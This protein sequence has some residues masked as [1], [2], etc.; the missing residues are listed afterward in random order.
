VHHAELG[1]GHANVDRGLGVEEG[2][3][4]SGSVGILGLRLIGMFAGLLAGVLRASQYTLLD[5]L[6][7]GA[8]VEMV[9]NVLGSLVLLI[10]ETVVSKVC[11]LD[12]IL[13]KV[14]LDGPDSRTQTVN[15]E[16]V[17]RRDRRGG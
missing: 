4:L 13:L 11:S 12:E 17:R 10:R 7:L 16:S 15:A 1:L 2:G 6:V 8:I 5:L 9:L 3:V 14:A